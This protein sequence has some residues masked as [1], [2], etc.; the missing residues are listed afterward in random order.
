[1]RFK[2]LIIAITVLSFSANVCSVVAYDMSSES[3]NLQIEGIDMGA[4]GEMK[5]FSDS[6]QGFFSG[7]TMKEVFTSHFSWKMA[8]IFLVGFLMVFFIFYLVVKKVFA[9]KR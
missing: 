9:F 1:M 2:E 3:Y 6:N 4:I 8:L 7:N 5:D